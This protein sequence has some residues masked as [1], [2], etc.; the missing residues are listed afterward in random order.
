[1]L[2][3]NETSLKKYELT[4]LYYSLFENILYKIY[5]IKQY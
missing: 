3:T 2:A 5:H 4:H 1:M